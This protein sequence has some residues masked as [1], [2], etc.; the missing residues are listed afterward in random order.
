MEDKMQNHQKIN[1]EVSSCMYNEKD[2]NSCLL[3]DI[4]VKNCRDYNASCPEDSM[5]ASYK[6]R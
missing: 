3:K 1:C 5:C 6:C 4:I 2:N